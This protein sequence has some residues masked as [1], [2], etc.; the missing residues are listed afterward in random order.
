MSLAPAPAPTTSS[1]RPPAAPEPGPARTWE[2][3][4]P[5]P[6]AASEVVEA[7]DTVTAETGDRPKRTVRTGGSRG[8]THAIRL[9]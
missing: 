7:D 9:R 5:L 1:P 2:R 4:P 6:Y 8:A 3:V